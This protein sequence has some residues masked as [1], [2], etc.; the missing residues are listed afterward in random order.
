MNTAFGGSSSRQPKTRLV[1][2]YPDGRRFE[3]SKRGRMWEWDHGCESSHLAAVKE[4]L[5]ALGAELVR[6]KVGTS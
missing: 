6:E 1:A 5:A 2:I 4:H 3:V